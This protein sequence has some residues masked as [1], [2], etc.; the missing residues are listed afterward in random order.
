[1]NINE[2][3]FPQVQ[4]GSRILWEDGKWYVYTS[5]EWVLETN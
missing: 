1:M 4:E 5:G 3:N 2:V